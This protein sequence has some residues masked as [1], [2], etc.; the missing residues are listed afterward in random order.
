MQRT[1]LVAYLDEYLR[2]GEIN[3][4]SLNGLQIEGAEE[5]SHV[6]FAV[7]ARLAAFEEAGRWGAELVI[8]H[9]GLFWDKVKPLVG[10]RYRRV[11]SL[12]Q[13][14]IALYA[15]HLPLD[16]HPEVGN[17]AQLAR[18][19]RLEETAPT[20]LYHGELLGLGGMLKDGA[21]LGWVTTYCACWMPAGRPTAWR[22]SR[23]AQRRWPVRS[24]LPDSTPTSLEKC[25]TRSSRRWRN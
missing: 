17:N 1:E 4:R 24:P 14:G 25:R 2:V 8:V 5:I 19:M 13:N 23:A 15:A 21:D 16:V 6:A 10:I 11:R 12:V 9:H 20:G 22:A 18:I 3:D 7:D